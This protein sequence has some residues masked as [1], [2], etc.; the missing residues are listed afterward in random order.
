M[1]SRDP[2]HRLW[3]P[4]IAAQLSRLGLLGPD[5]HVHRSVANVVASAVQ[6]DDL[7]MTMRDPRA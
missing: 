4:D 7:A 3:S 2:K 5:G 1:K 6:G